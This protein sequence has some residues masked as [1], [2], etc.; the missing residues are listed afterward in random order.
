MMM[1]VVF[2]LVVS[3]LS[4][5]LGKLSRKPPSTTEVPE[6]PE[7]MDDAIEWQHT[8]CGAEVDHDAEFCH[9]CGEEI[10]FFTDDEG[11]DHDGLPMWKLGEN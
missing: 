3:F 2:L 11:V 8:E 9:V 7:E 5:H 10:D 1:D 6:Q 4:F